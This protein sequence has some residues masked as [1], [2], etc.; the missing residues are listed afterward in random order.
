MKSSFAKKLYNSVVGIFYLFLSLAVFVSVLMVVLFTPAYWGYAQFDAVGWK[1][2]FFLVL[3]F[4]ISLVACISFIR[5]AMSSED[6]DLYETKEHELLDLVNSVSESVLGTKFSKVFLSEEQTLCTF[7][8]WNKRFLVLNPLIMSQL[9]KE[10]LKAAIAHECA[11][12]HFNAMFYDG[13]VHLVKRMN[14]G[15]KLFF[16]NYSNSLL[17]LRFFCEKQFGESNVYYVGVFCTYSI[18]LFSRA[19][20]LLYVLFEWALSLV[21]IQKDAEYYCDEVSLKIYGKDLFRESILK[22]FTFDI[23]SDLIKQ[24]GVNKNYIDYS[25]VL[26]TEFDD[27]RENELPD[28]FLLKVSTNTHPS[29]VSRLS[30]AESYASSKTTNNEYFDKGMVDK[31][32]SE[33]IEDKFDE[34]TEVTEIETL[35]NKY[36]GLDKSVSGDDIEINSEEQEYECY[37]KWELFGVVYPIKVAVIEFFTGSFEEALALSAAYVLPLVLALHS[38]FFIVETGLIID[39]SDSPR[40]LIVLLVGGSYGI[41][42]LLGIGFFSRIAESTNKW[43]SATKIHLY[44]IIIYTAL[45]SCCYLFDAMFIAHATILVFTAIIACAGLFIWL[46]KYYNSVWW[47]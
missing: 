19:V 13:V 7:L 42:G 18:F 2:Y 22:I 5:T 37:M 26:T 30:R 44:L 34:V 23:V 43:L 36:E 16:K 31:I 1:S 39:D 28:N 45:F 3:G 12:Y 20:S 15:F 33:L 46:Y 11:H 21:F 47:Y 35:R 40:I 9:T 4:V 14:Y 38:T 29:V 6:F 27:F 10:E 17:E 32:W 41:L 8:Y 24:K 25:R